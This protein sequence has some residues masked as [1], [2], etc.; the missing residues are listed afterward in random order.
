[1]AARAWDKAIKYLEKLEARY[2]YGR[3][4]QQAQLDVAYA[5]WK[6]GERASAL[7][8]ADRFIKLYP[9]HANVDYAYYLKGLVNFNENEGLFSLI[10]S[11]DMSERDS[12][13]SRESFE[14]FKELA[15]RFP[16]KNLSC[17]LTYRLAVMADATWRAFH[18]SKA[19]PSR[20][21]VSAMA[22]YPFSFSSRSTQCVRA[23]F[24]AWSAPP[25]SSPAESKARMA[26]SNR[27]RA[28]GPRANGL[29]IG[30][31]MPDPLYASTRA[32]HCS[33]V[34]ATLVASIIASLIVEC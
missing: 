34:P 18:R 11:P 20:L 15:T 7:A 21:R 3:F 33:G 26:A 10:D 1:M 27:A 16:A 25:V 31:S 23:S 2:P 4:A 19:H 22:R 32:R 13:G 5:Y 28:P 29:R 30:S 8:A 24:A 6:Q 12:K 17:S 9:N 14:A